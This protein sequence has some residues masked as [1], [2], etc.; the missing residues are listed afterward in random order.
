VQISDLAPIKQAIQPKV[1]N[2]KSLEF[3]GHADVVC[4]EVAESS[5]ERRGF[6][7]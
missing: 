6:Y 4:G 5:L 1:V 3:V 2:P 7:A